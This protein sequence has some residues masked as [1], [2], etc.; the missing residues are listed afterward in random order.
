MPKPYSLDLRERVFRSERDLSAKSYVYVWAD[1]VYQQARL[2]TRR[3]ASWSSSA[4]R[5][6]SRRRSRR[7][8]RRPATPLRPT[9][10]PLTPIPTPTS[11]I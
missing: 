10:S 2:R 3:N 1:G 5:L 8:I 9:P 4:R 7:P 6:S 11:S